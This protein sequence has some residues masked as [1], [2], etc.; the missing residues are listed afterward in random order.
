MMYV[1]DRV[2]DSFVIRHVWRMRSG[3]CVGY[4]D[5]RKGMARCAMS[6]EMCSSTFRERDVVE[7]RIVKYFEISTRQG[8]FAEVVG[9]F[10]QKGD[11]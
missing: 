1:V 9:M 7:Q 11:E 5:F 8:T 4:C 2:C 6:N 3:Y 10:G